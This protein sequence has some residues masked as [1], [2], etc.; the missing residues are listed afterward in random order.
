[1]QSN[2]FKQKFNLQDQTNETDTCTR[3]AQESKEKLRERE[4]LKQIKET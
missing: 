4:G 3:Q 2:T 1:M